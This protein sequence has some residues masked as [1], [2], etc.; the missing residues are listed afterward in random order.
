DTILRHLEDTGR[1]PADY[2]VIITGDL[3]KLGHSLSLEMLRDRGLD[4]PDDAFQDCGVLMYRENQGVQ[5]GGSGCACSAV[6]IRS[7]AT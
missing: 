4:I 2:D 6:G 1:T 7:C 3:G 5:S